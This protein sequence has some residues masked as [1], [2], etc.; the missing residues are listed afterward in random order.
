MLL[1]LF[2]FLVI[3]M[4]KSMVFL[5]NLKP[6]IRTVNEMPMA[7]HN[8]RVYSML[9]TVIILHVMGWGCSIIFF[10]LHLFFSLLLRR[11]Y[12]GRW[13]VILLPMATVW[14]FVSFISF[15]PR[16]PKKKKYEQTNRTASRPI[17]LNRIAYF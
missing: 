15:L 12:L 7:W 3:K 6:T 8:I 16:H 5:F 2:F 9:T 17:S 11:V 4:L 1:L 13:I 10:L 14:F